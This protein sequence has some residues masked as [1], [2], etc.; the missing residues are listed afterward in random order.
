MRRPPL[1][2][3]EPSRRADHGFAPL[4]CG[5]HRTSG[6]PRRTRRSDCASVARR[7]S[8]TVGCRCAERETF[9]KHGVISIADKRFCHGTRGGNIRTPFPIGRRSRFEVKCPGLRRT[10]VSGY[11]ALGTSLQYAHMQQTSRE[12][13]P[14]CALKAQIASHSGR[15]MTSHATTSL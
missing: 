6:R 1:A 9:E 13:E 3:A 11:N 8:R 7:H 10:I 5:L 14:A 4:P 12:T 2:D 15:E